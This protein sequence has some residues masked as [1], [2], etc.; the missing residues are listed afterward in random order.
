MARATS[1]LRGVQSAWVKERT[2]SV[3]NGQIDGY[4]V[5][6]MITF[7]MDDSEDVGACPKWITACLKIRTGCDPGQAGYQ[8]TPPRSTE[9]TPRRPCWLRWALARSTLEIA[10]PY[11]PL[12]GCY[13]TPGD[14]EQIRT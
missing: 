9:F 4:R 2:F 3:E 12:A 10:P 14:D 5:N 7:L 6:L 8:G 1:S 13:M 11:G